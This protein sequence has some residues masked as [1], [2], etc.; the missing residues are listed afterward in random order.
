MAKLRRHLPKSVFVIL[1]LSLFISLI[2]V[3]F[4]TLYPAQSSQIMAITPSDLTYGDTTITGILQ[5]DAPVGAAGKY[6]VTLLDMRV[7]MLDVQGLDALLGQTVTVAGVL[8]PD[9]LSMTVSSITQ[10]K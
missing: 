1:G 7:V 3:G 5:K 6:F 8:T 2:Y 4:R 9:P 10:I